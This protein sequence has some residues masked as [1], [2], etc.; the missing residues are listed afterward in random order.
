MSETAHIEKPRAQ[1]FTGEE[2]DKLAA[3]LGLSQAQVDFAHEEDGDV[4]RIVARRK[5]TAEE[6]DTQAEGQ[7]GT[8][9]PPAV[10]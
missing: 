8:D 1:E 9:E 6:A 3:E 10:A 7:I 4:H 5:P 2:F